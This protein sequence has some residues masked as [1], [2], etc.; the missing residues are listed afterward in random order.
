MTPDPTWHC[1]ATGKRRPKPK[2]KRSAGHQ[3][4][5]QS[6]LHNLL[7]LTCPQPLAQFRIQTVK[8]GP[9]T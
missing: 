6:C 7:L 8:S 3:Y 9:G 5:P 2:T 1:N 4:P